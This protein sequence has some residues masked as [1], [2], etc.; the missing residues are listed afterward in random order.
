MQINTGRAIQ[1]G[2]GWIETSLEF[3]VIAVGESIVSRSQVR[4]YDR[5]WSRAERRAFSPRRSANRQDF[6]GG[7]VSKRTS[8]QQERR[9]EQS[10]LDERGDELAW[11]D[12]S[13][14]FRGRTAL[15]YSSYDA[16]ET[17]CISCSIE[18]APRARAGTRKWKSR[19]T[20]MIECRDK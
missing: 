6:V 10:Q 17:V 9:A 8:L 11:Q 14:E 16:T 18:A 19:N 1:F 13:G 3:W 20:S 15:P 5:F 2:T 4:C 7:L 12:R